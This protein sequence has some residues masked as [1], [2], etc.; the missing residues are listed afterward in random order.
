MLFLMVSPAAN[1]SNNNTHAG[2]RTARTDEW[3]RQ[4]ALYLAYRRIYING[5]RSGQTVRPRV[6][7]RA[8]WV[9]RT[10]RYEPI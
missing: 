7:T 9:R 4:F 2:K 10:L 3:Q 6:D 8:T 1:R 5:F